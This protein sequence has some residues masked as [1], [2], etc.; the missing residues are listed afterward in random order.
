MNNIFFKSID[1]G[2]VPLSITGRKISGPGRPADCEIST[3][4]NLIEKMTCQFSEE[5]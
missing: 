5:K 2:C 1:Y 4:Y 3:Y